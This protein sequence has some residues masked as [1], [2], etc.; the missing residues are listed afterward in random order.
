MFSQFLTISS[1]LFGAIHAAPLPY[2]MS[3][4]KAQ[5]AT[6]DLIRAAQ[7]AEPMGIKDLRSDDLTCGKDAFVKQK[8]EEPEIQAGEYVTMKWS[9]DMDVF[10]KGP[11]ITYMAEC[12]KDDCEKSDVTTLDWFKIDE[13]GPDLNGRWYQSHLDEGVNVR[14]PPE[15]RDGK[16][17]LRH[18]VIVLDKEPIK[19][20]PS[21]AA[22]EVVDGVSEY[23]TKDYRVHIPGVY[24]RDD[25]GLQV[26]TDSDPYN[27]INFPGPKVWKGGNDD[28]EYVVESQSNTTA[29]SAD[30]DVDMAGEA[31]QV[32][33]LANDLNSTSTYSSFTSSTATT[34]KPTSTS[35]PKMTVEEASY[36]PTS[37]SFGTKPSKTPAPYKAATYMPSTTSS[38]SS[39]T[40]GKT[41]NGLDDGTWNEMKYDNGVFT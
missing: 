9:P 19:L 2:M 33:F 32:Q 23:P 18:E 4:Q 20:Y 30:F 12:Y 26:V 31:Y 1:I 41:N 7:V 5:V 24:D 16:Y 36:T 38:K 22:I 29:E 13:K 40:N 37:T 3:S 10:G 25:V 27:Y 28:D 39:N 15:L 11:I 17:I 34:L 14:I 6:P 8:G 21:C 35:T